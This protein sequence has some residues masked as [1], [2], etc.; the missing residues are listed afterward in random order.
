MF[1][2]GMSVREVVGHMRDLQGGDVW[3]DLISAGADALLDD[4]ST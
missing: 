1:A 2:H 4:S 3:P